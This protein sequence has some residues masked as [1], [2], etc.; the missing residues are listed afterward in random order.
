MIILICLQKNAILQKL[1]LKVVIFIFF[2]RKIKIK[3]IINNEYEFYEDSDSNEEIFNATK[4][5]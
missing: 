5:L 3:Y 1:T 2:M 4:V